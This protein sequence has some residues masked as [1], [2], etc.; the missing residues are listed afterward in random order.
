MNSKTQCSRIRNAR[1]K[2]SRKRLRSKDSSIEVL[3]EVLKGNSRRFHPQDN[4]LLQRARRA[5]NLLM[6]PAT[7]ILKSTVRLKQELFR[8]ASTAFSISSLIRLRRRMALSFLISWDRLIAT[9]LLPST[10]WRKMPSL[11]R[12]L[13]KA[14]TWNFFLN[15]KT[16]LRMYLRIRSPARSSSMSTQSWLKIPIIFNLAKS[17]VSK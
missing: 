15:S 3:K 7:H 1:L 10:F 13:K 5:V 14:K 9:L 8:S 11:R 6:S 2:N 16:T 12:L 4:R 17:S